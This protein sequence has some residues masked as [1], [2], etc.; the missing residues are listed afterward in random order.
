MS[1]PFSNV[2][3]LDFYVAAVVLI[4]LRSAPAISLTPSDSVGTM[5]SL[6]LNPDLKSN[7]NMVQYKFPNYLIFIEKIIG[8]SYKFLCTDVEFQS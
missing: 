2:H 7:S 4:G 6:E 8:A 5:I 3:N 1:A